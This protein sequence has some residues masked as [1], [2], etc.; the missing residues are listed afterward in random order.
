MAKA[1]C[2]K[3]G[4]F[5]KLLICEL[6]WRFGKLTYRQGSGRGLHMVMKRGSDCW[7]GAFGLATLRLR[8]GR[9][10]LVNTLSDVPG[11]QTQG[12]T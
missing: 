8:V 1:L 12:V 10:H 7:K 11:G 5:G 6:P 4:S 2:E 9:S 3:L